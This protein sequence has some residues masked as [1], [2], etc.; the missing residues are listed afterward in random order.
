MDDDNRKNFIALEI[1]IAA[2][3][4]ERCEYHEEVIYQIY[5]DLQEAYK[6]GNSNW[7]ANGYSK[8]FDD[9]RDMTDTIKAVA[10]DPDYGNDQCER[11]E[12]QRAE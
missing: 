3:Y 9:R 5:G 10:E 4:F 6:Y 12:V 11:C 8:I 2:N 1:L 7:E